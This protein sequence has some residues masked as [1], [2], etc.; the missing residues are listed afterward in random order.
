MSS[1]SITREQMKL[2]L[3]PAVSHSRRLRRF[4]MSISWVGLFGAAII[5]A[6]INIPAIV[7]VNKAG[8]QR[9]APTNLVAQVETAEAAPVDEISPP[10]EPAETPVADLTFRYEKVG[11]SA[12]I[13]WE[14][15]YSAKNIKVA[16]Q[17]GVAHVKGSAQPGGNGT[18]IITG[19]SSNTAWAKGGYKTVFAPLLKSELGDT[20]SVDYSGTTYTYQVTEVYEVDPTRVELLNGKDGVAIR[21]ITCTPLGTDKRRLIIDAKQIS[22]E[23]TG[24]WQANAIN[25]AMIVATR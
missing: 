8:D 25:A 9:L 19:H 5:Y 22:P 18:T 16:L 3:Q 13:E 24:S 6:S 12:P 7:A 2:L 4:D 20:F 21:L 10:T 17:S 15:P 1:S 23:H 14:T 11:I